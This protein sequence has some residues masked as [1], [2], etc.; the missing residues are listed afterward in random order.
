MAASGL[1][2]VLRVPDQFSFATGPQGINNGPC[3]PGVS[4]STTTD[5]SRLAALAPPDN[6]DIYDTQTR[7]KVATLSVPGVLFIEIS[8]CGKYLATLQRHGTCQGEP[9][10]NLKVWDLAQQTVLLALHQ[11]GTSKE[12]WPSFQWAD[13][14]SHAALMV[15]NTIHIYHQQGDAMTSE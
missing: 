1:P 6:V 12:S 15:T 3:N 9:P 10:R 7:S 5:G 11:R 4:T 14:D 13:D 8:P 2:L